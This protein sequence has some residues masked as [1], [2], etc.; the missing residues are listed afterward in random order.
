MKIALAAVLLL[1]AGCGSAD[2]D[3]IGDDVAG[4]E[5]VASDEPDFA[6]VA[7]EP[8]PEPALPS[9]PETE[10]VAD[11]APPAAAVDPLAPEP[12]ARP[13]AP[14]PSFD[15]NARLNRVEALVCSDPELAGLDRRLARDFASAMANADQEQ[16]ERLTNLGRRYLA[17]RNRCPVRDCVVQSYRWYL[18]DIATV[19]ERSTT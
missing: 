16:R 1:L 17:D 18:R 9:A 19:M 10:T 8:E 6:N 2:Q 5:G 15:C 11:A 7:D 14:S 3:K 12:A 13:A 4:A